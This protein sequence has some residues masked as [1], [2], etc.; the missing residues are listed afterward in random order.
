MRYIRWILLILYILLVAG[1][2]SYA[3]F[4]LKDEGIIVVGA[5]TIV[6]LIV[7]LG[8]IGVRDLCLPVHSRRM[9]IPIIIAGAMLAVLAVSMLLALGELSEIQGPDWL[10]YLFW[11]A[12]ALNWIVWSILLYYYTRGVDRFDVIRRIAFILFAGSAAELLAAFPSHLIVS[13]RPGCFVGWFTLSAI[14]AGVCVMVWS[15]GP[16]IFLLFVYGRYKE[17]RKIPRCRNCGYDLRG[18][19]HERC[20]ECGTEVPK[21]SAGQ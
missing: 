2:M 3:V 9:I 21:K 15:F 18:L 7:F 16:G 1:L 11:P 5:V 8:T 14:I 12:L 19:D 13:R 20:P 6:S 10:A 4:G 17:D